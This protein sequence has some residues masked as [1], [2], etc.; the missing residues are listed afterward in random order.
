MKFIYILATSFTK[1]T[2]FSHKVSISINTLFPPLRETLYAFRV[3]LFAEASEFFTHAVF[4]VVVVVRKTASSE[5]ILQGAKK[6]GSRR[7]L[8]RDCWEDEDLIHLPV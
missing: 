5:C 1:L 2:L 3:K 6:G 4:Q 7:V 8:N